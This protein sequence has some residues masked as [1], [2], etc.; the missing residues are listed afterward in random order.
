MNRSRLPIVII[1]LVLAL[2]AGGVMHW[3]WPWG[4]AQADSKGQTPCEIAVSLAVPKTGDNPVGAAL[5]TTGGQ[6]GGAADKGATKPA[7]NPTDGNTVN[8]DESKAN[9]PL[10]ADPTQAFS[11]CLKD[12]DQREKR[13]EAANVLGRNAS[14]PASW[15]GIAGLG[16]VIS[17]LVASVAAWLF[18]GVQ[19]GARQEIDR[20]TREIREEATKVEA[21]KEV[22][23]PL[24]ARVAELDKR[25]ANIS[26]QVET[27][28]A[29]SREPPPQ[30]SPLAT[31]TRSFHPRP[32]N[33]R[34]EEVVAPV[35]QPDPSPP[36]PAPAIAPPPPSHHAILADYRRLLTSPAA[37]AQDLDG[38][39][40]QHGALRNINRDGHG[41]WRLEPHVSGD[42]TQKL[43][44]L[45]LR[46][47][48]ETVLIV[49]SSNFIKEFAMTFKETLEAG[50]EIKELFKARADGS[51]MLALEAPATARRDGGDQL[52]GIERGT[53]GGFVR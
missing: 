25:I 42:V 13:L 15:M 20:L 11:N 43:V 50:F 24:D 29:V 41:G 10:P 31:P 16:L 2:L 14:A 36:S 6:S 47:A 8:I 32:D 38:A 48:A 34:Q 5:T 7:R 9:E 12:L 19:H 40:A 4:K 51:G 39:L 28:A 45:V 26:Q 49:P 21:V 46:D 53:L 33:W 1:A 23:T 35:L 44:A 37:T 27:L 17:L 22:M 18:R 52:V 3:G 30:P